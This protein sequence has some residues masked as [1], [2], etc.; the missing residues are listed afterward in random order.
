M[1]AM[2]D[3]ARAVSDARDEMYVAV[4]AAQRDDFTATADALERA[5]L[6]LERAESDLREG[7]A[8]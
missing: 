3:F 4:A 2:E 6:L 8:A 5:V 1:S 7:L